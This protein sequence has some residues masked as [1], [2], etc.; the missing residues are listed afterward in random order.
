[1]IPAV[2]PRSESQATWKAEPET[3]RKG[4][5]AFCPKMVPKKAGLA[6]GI[7]ARGLL[8]VEDDAAATLDVVIFG[9]ASKQPGVVQSTSST[10]AMPFVLEGGG[11][12]VKRRDVRRRALAERGTGTIRPSGVSMLRPRSGDHRQRSMAARVSS[13]PDWSR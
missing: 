2:R 8:I 1:M 11:R 3:E 5:A 7:T 6:A 9:P 12:K 10:V 4:I 13:W